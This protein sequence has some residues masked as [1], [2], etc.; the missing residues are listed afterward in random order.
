M[1]SKFI[2]KKPNPTF[3]GIKREKDNNTPIRVNW[4][5]EDL[6]LLIIVGPAGLEPA[7][8]GL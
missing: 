4:F 5:L 6:I 8:D 1:S 3:G 7:T 2:P